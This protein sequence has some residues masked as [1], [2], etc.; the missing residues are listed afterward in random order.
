MVLNI[1]KTFE[2]NKSTLLIKMSTKRTTTR[3]GEAYAYRMLW[4]FNP[5]LC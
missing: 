1:T 4:N 3:G 2:Y 5:N